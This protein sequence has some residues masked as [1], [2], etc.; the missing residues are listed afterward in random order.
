M[1]GWVQDLPLQI[2]KLQFLKF[3][4]SYVKIKGK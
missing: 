3:K 4:Q 1:L 2:D